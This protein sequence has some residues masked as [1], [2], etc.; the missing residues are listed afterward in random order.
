MR[1]LAVLFL[2]MVTLMPSWAIAK[3]KTIF[4]TACIMAYTDQ[5]GNM[6]K[7]IRSNTITILVR[8]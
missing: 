7:V 6:T 2:L 3:E 4:S 1:R 8:D 5:I